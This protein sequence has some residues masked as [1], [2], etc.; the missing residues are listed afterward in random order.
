MS[1]LRILENLKTR[2]L[3]DDQFETKIMDHLT[4]LNL[5]VNSSRAKDVDVESAKAKDTLSHY[6]LRLA[7]CRSEDL[8]RWFVGQESA[9]LRL[10]LEK[11]T[12]DERK[13]FMQDNNLE[14]HL[15]SSA[16]KEELKDQLEAAT[17]NYDLGGKAGVKVAAGLALVATSDFFKV[18]FEHALDLVKQRAVLLR[19]GFAYVPVSRVVTIVVAHFA[20][21]LDEALLHASK[22]AGSFEIRVFIV[23]HASNSLSI[24]CVTGGCALPSILVE[25]AFHHQ[26]R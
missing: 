9:L 10:R 22:V 2:N 21:L 14:Y 5:N 16:E 12:S 11:L 18:P 20:K 8:R 6:V 17:S 19:E 13:T 25:L 4:R 26:R 1:V 24:V 15:L 3:D 7:Y 23:H